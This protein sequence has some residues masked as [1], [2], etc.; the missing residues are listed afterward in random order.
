MHRSGWRLAGVCTIKE[1]TRSL[2]YMKAPNPAFYSMYKQQK[3][4]PQELPGR[5]LGRCK[6]NT[7]RRWMMQLLLLQC[8][9]EALAPL[10]PFTPFF[11]GPGLA[12]QVNA[13]VL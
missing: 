8:K 12:E 7:L 3:R 11:N 13:Q 1:S 9:D 2:V 5:R 4:V 6:Y 10:T